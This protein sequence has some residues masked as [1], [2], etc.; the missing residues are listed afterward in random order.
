[1]HKVL[2]FHSLVR[3]LSANFCL[4]FFA[5]ALQAQDLGF[6]AP[7]PVADTLASIW[8]DEVNAFDA[9][10]GI[11]GIYLPGKWYW[12]G[13][14]GNALINPQTPA[15]T[16]M[17][18]RAGSLSKSL[19]AA[20][21]LLLQEQ[22]NLDLDDLI[23][24]YLSPTLAAS[25]PNSGQM[26]IRQLL[27]HTSGVGNY[28]SSPA[29]FTTLLV[30]GLGHVFSPA[31]LIGFGVGQ[32]ASFPPG[33]SWAYSNTN[34]VIAA[35]IIEDVTNGP[36]ESFVN[37]NFLQPLGLQESYYPTTDTLPGSFMGS[38]FDANNTPPKEEFSYVGPSGSYG[39]G[40]LVSKLGDMI[41]WL[42]ALME[43]QILSP[44]SLAEMQTFVNASW[45][46]ID[47]GLGLGEYDNGSYSAIGHTGAVFNS[48]NMQYVSNGNYYVVYNLTDQDFPHFALMDRL[49]AFLNPYIQNC[50]G[51]NPGLI[52]GSSVRGLNAGENIL[53]QAP[54]TPGGSYQWFK[55]GQII[56]GASNADLAVAQTGSYSVR[57]SNAQGCVEMTPSVVIQDCSPYQVEIDGFAANA[58]FCQ[59]SSV[60][61]TAGS[62][63]DS[64]SWSDPS[65]LLQS[66]GTNFSFIAN[67]NT[68]IFLNASS[69]I[70]CRATDTLSIAVIAPPQANLGADQSLCINSP[71]SLQSGSPADSVNWYNISGTL[72]LANSPNY[73]FNL[74][75]SGQ[76]V[77]EVQNLCGTVRDTLS[78]TTINPPI[79]NLGPDVS[80][81]RNTPLNLTN[82]GSGDQVDWFDLTGNLL[83]A[84]SRTYTFTLNSNQSLISTVS[85]VCGTAQ[86]SLDIGLL[87]EPMADLG[88]DITACPGLDVNLIAGANGDI[89]NWY[90]QNGGLLSSNSPDYFF[91]LQNPG[92]IVTEVINSCGTA[93]DTLNFTVLP[94]AEA[95]LGPDFSDCVNSPQVFE[96]GNPGDSVNWYNGAGILL[97]ANTPRYNFQ[98]SNSA[99]IIGEVYNSCGSTQDTVFLQAIPEPRV[100][101]GP[102]F[103]T[104]PGSML[105][106]S[107]GQSGDLVNWFDG[108]GALLRANSLDYSF[109]LSQSIRLIVERIANC[110][111]ARDTL[112]INAE[113]IAEIDLGEDIRICEGEVAIISAG[114]IPDQINWYDGNGSLISQDTNQ[115]QLTVDAQTQIIA[116][117]L[118]TCGND[119]DTIELTAVPLPQVDLGPDT[120]V[121]PGERISFSAGQVG[122]IVNWYD[123]DGSLLLGNNTSFFFNPQA[124]ISLIA[125]VINPDGCLGRDTVFVDIN[126][127]SLTKPF[128]LG[129]LIYPNPAKDK[130]SIK[131]MNF[132][133]KSWSWQIV[134]MDGKALDSGESFQAIEQLEIGKLPEGN[135]MLLIE[136]GG[137]KTYQIFQKSD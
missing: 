75:N 35:L 96:L 53:L 90:N 68:Q 69:E 20:S 135:Y 126:T 114:N 66:S 82:G 130:I 19:V 119:R 9:E 121:I 73:S 23:P 67:Q 26:S 88:D 108:N 1:M 34:Y 3:L 16:S 41:R 12:A 39:A 18:F 85:N 47:Y 24:Q 109:R 8:A 36:Y 60:Q 123:G 50:N 120:A 83:L 127:T 13:Q 25:I 29:F 45:P 79:S 56:G 40:A 46:N 129:I 31:D 87:P 77:V 64:L 11:I 122:D 89:V 116:E 44:N 72:L 81:C 70:G 113:N 117:L 4:I 43:A 15:D 62:P 33:G 131:W 28:T 80:Y 103:S 6:P 104:C 42:E 65:G 97:A 27:N 137:L 110:G 48:S 84:N 10:G 86:D 58:D 125:E 52:A 51:F 102:N 133:L 100:D 106:F 94:L 136:Q 63:I 93:F 55:D 78:L 118:S 17:H 5:N 54:A 21:L 128:E 61:L 37:S 38:Y 22:G 115:I 2:R 7:T 91:S 111:T 92:A 95:N 57:I 105:S 49:Y 32:G 132:A 98:L 124:P 112:D 71:L 99:S 76:I 134:G 14:S 59:G 107:A 30:Q 74:S 101:L